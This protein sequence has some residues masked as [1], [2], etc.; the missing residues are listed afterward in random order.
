MYHYKRL[1]HLREDAD[2]KQVEIAKVL[3]DTQQH[4]QL[5]ESG[6]R[7]T[8]FWVIIKLAE[9]YK[10]S[11][12]YIAG[13]TNDKGGQHINNEDEIEMLNLYNNLSEQNKGRTKERMEMLIKIQ[14][15]K[16]KENI[17]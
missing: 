2:L 15:K 4:Y 10:V 7:E 16:K 17:N 11:I 13:T 8:P 6:K 12:D 14:E 5:Y 1:R 9:Y 3:N